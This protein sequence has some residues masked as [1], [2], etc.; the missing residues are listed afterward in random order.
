MS[1]AVSEENQSVSSVW[2]ILDG[3]V[4]AQDTVTARRCYSDWAL[5]R[6]HRVFACLYA[7]GNE[8]KIFLAQ[9]RNH[10]AEHF[11]QFLDAERKVDIAGLP[12]YMTWQMDCWAL[13]AGI[14]GW[15]SFSDCS[16]GM[17]AMTFKWLLGLVWSMIFWLF[18]L[19]MYIWSRQIKGA[20]TPIPLGADVEIFRFD[21]GQDQ[22][23]GHQFQW[24]QNQSETRQ[25]SLIGREK[26]FL[27][28]SGFLTNYK[29]LQ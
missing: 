20:S 3:Q 25:G 13:E 22:T 26:A 8:I 18:S 23:A 12:S 27:D 1:I 19:W 11:V 2:N 6:S 28:G 24:S 7:I 14:D 17:L 10:K 9:Q 29:K 5:L 21:Q 16:L 15:L 4:L